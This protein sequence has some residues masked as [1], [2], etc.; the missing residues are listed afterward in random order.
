MT[1][2]RLF[3][4]IDLSPEARS[5][6]TGLK[7]PAA[8]CRPVPAS[9]LHLTLRF[10]GDVD[11]SQLTEV[12]AALAGINQGPFHLNLAGTGV[13]PNSHR[14]RVLWVGVA[15]VPE[16]QQLQRL[17]ELAV[18]AAGIPADERRFSPHITIARLAGSDPVPVRSFLDRYRA[19]VAPTFTAV[20]FNLYASRLSAAGAEHT[21]LQSYPLT[22]AG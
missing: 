5:A 12:Q 18:Q 13:F 19:F 16:L 15:P 21:I 9:Q 3:I 11:D 14:P 4:A 1:R 20:S 17:V 7:L 10:I 8:N 22:A 2:H 6:L